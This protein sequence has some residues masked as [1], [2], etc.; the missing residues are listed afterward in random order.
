MMISS[1]IEMVTPEMAMEWLT[2]E[3]NL[4][5]RPLR[6]PVVRKY[7]RDMSAR[8]WMFN[9]DT[10]KFDWN[11]KLL[12]GQHRLHA[13]ID[14][15]HPAEFLIVRNLNP[16][17]YKSIDIGAR[18]TPGDMM[19]HAGS[20]HASA[21]A[22]AAKVLHWYE[23]GQKDFTLAQSI[24]EL[25]AVYQKHPALEA[26]VARYNNS[27]AV[28]KKLRVGSAWPAFTYLVHRKLPDE[29]EEFIAGVSDGFDLKGKG[30]GKGDPRHTLREWFLNRLHRKRSAPNDERFC[31]ITK[32]WNAFVE[33][34]SMQALSYR[35]NEEPPTLIRAPF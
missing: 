3:T 6:L 23:N 30:I 25:V 2:T 20:K 9:G 18:R 34:R 33:G 11:G 14:A 21:A 26:H 4:N 28:R 13:I 22:A 10:L 15:N 32:A 12:D 7:V 16:D 17:A 1:R 27:S 5:N 29:L 8:N 35:F 19:Q 31:I 24:A